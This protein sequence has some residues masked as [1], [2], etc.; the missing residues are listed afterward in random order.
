MVYLL[1]I[2]IFHSY[3][4]LPEGKQKQ[5]LPVASTALGHAMVVACLGRSAKRR[6][7]A[8]GHATADTL[9]RA[10]SS[11][12]VIW[13]DDHGID[14]RKYFNERRHLNIKY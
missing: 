2:V 3:V 12:L 1:K 7:A 6:L 5:P 11:S 14:V 8:T 4:K 9:A 13:G 10:R